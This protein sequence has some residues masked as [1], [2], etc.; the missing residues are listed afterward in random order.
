VQALVPGRFRR[1]PSTPPAGG[2]GRH[3][4]EDA[5][6]HK[7]PDK[8]LV[9]GKPDYGKLVTSYGEAQAALMRK[10]T[11]VRPRSSASSTRAVEGRTGDAGRLHGRDK[12]ILG[13]REITMVK[14]IR[15]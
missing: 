6:P 13:D 9:D 1:R 8:F 11:E 7:V 14:D 5:G 12:L 10:G 15:C 3:P 2:P 4:L